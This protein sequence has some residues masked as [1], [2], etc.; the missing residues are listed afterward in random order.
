MFRLLISWSASK[1][2]RL[3]LC[4]VNLGGRP[5][6]GGTLNEESG[7]PPSPLLPSPSPCSRIWQMDFTHNSLVWEVEPQSTGVESHAE[8]ICSWS[9]DEKKGGRGG[10]ELGPRN[11]AL[12]EEARFGRTPPAR[13][14]SPCPLRASPLQYPCFEKPTRPPSLAIS[15]TP[16]LRMLRSGL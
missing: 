7:T 6:L 9:T 1:Y 14:L 10:G 13:G 2:T 15:R 8:S 3:P 4:P 16:S 12:S 11:Q 5:F